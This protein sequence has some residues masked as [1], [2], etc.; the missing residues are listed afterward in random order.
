M[1][2][3]LLFSFYLFYIF[4]FLSLLFSFFSVFP[5]YFTILFCHVIFKSLTL[6]SSVSPTCF[7]VPVFISGRKVNHH[8][9]SLGSF[10]N[11]RHLRV[12]QKDEKKKKC[13]PLNG[14][15]K[16][17]E[18]VKMPY[19]LERRT[20]FSEQKVSSWISQDCLGF[21]VVINSPQMS[22]A[23]SKKSL[24]LADVQHG[25]VEDLAP[26]SHLGIQD[27]APSVISK[28]TSKPTLLQ[29][30]RELEHL[31]EIKCFGLEVIHTTS[32]HNSRP[33][34]WPIYLQRG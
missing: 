27:T 13:K 34:A 15:I 21:L 6:S 14:W 26:P 1:L 5:F 24:F 30:Q 11:F 22:M 19:D 16:L 31:L 8:S 25:P 33:M 28:H 7:T 18:K 29:R 12:Y 3:S 10:G 32:A 20:I 23:K 9:A 4:H 17:L 2:F